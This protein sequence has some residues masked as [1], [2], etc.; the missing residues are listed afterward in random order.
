VFSSIIYA[1]KLKI[2]ILRFIKN[3]CFKKAGFFR[4]SKYGICTGRSFRVH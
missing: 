1:I 2:V 4:G 3:Y